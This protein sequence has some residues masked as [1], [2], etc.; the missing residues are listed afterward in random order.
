MREQKEQ[1]NT[2]SCDSVTITIGTTSTA[3]VGATA[4]ADPLCSGDSTVLMVT[5]GALGLG[6]DWQWYSG[7][8]GGTFVGTG[9]S[10]SVFPAATTT[11][12]VRAEGG[13]DTTTCAS[14]TITMNSAST[15]PTVSASVTSIC[16]GDSSILSITGG[17]LGTGATW[18]WYSASCGGVA[19]G[20]G[21]SITVTPLVTT[22]YYARAEGTCNT[23]V[24]D[25]VT[26]IISTLST[27]AVSAAATSNS[28]CVGDSTVLLVNGGVLGS[29]ANWAWY[30]ASC[31]G[32][33]VGTGDSLSVFPVVT[34]T[35][36]VRAEGGCDT[37]TCVSVAI[38]VGALSTTPTIAATTTLICAGDSSVISITGGA[39]GSGATWQWYSVSCGG[40]PVGTGTSITVTPLVTTA[41]FARAEGSCNTTSCDS[42]IVVVRTTSSPAVS[43]LPTP[44]TICAG[45]SSTLLIQGG[46]LGTGAN[47]KWYTG[48]CGGTFIGSGNSI[49]VSPII[50]S[51]YYVRA[52]GIC[53]TTICTSVMVIVDSL[54]VPPPAVTSEVRCF[55]EP[56]PDLISTGSQIKWYLNAA[57]TNLVYIGD[58]FATGETAPGIYTYFVTD[59][60]GGCQSPP[61]IATLTI[62]PSPPVVVTGRPTAI[63]PGD[64]TTLSA[65]NALTFLWS[66]NIGLRDTVGSVVRASPPNTMKYYVFGTDKMGCVGVDSIKIYVEG[67]GIVENGTIQ[68]LN[69]FPNP[70]LGSFMVDFIYEEGASVQLNVL[71]LMGQMVISKKIKAGRQGRCSQTFDLKEFAPGIYYLQVV[72]D[73]GTAIRKVIREN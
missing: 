30:S 47:W 53:D 22:T 20:A 66:P 68:Y 7:S 27:P 65:F 24:C 69:I 17:A 13:C 14:I 51:T 56:V 36:F 12:Y 23:T 50:S 67:T 63:L 33:L 34:T 62:H 37:T 43:I 5:G 32:T 45:N 44:D 71:N 57:L 29:G 61:A 35:Y 21:T 25:S 48:S 46:V 6:A 16:V 28:I 40:T 10:L 55:G 38:T 49:M 59:T 19:E 42:L 52:E 73:K 60:K 11:Y 39:L 41:Y 18:Q 4:S 70:T 58:T 9:D 3:P 26:I 1:C 54:V 8:C 31:G 72:T 15:T 2:T 64:S